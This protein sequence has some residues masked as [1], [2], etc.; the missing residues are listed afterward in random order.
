MKTDLSQM[1]R[2]VIVAGGLI[3]LMAGAHGAWA[4]GCVVGRSCQAGNIGSNFLMPGETEFTLSYRGF[5][6]NKHYNG[7]QRQH[8]RDIQKTFVINRQNIWNL[9]ATRG[10]TN[11]FSADIDIPYI[12]SGW[13]IPR[14]FP[15]PTTT[16]PTPLGPRYQQE[17]DG[18]GDIS[19]SGKYWLWDPE[20]HADSN[21]QLSLGIKAPTG[22][23][24]EQV[25]F[26][27]NSSA[28]KFAPTYID[29][30]IEPGDGGWG[31]PVGLEL[32][33]MLGKSSMTFFGEASYLINPRDTD[34]LV[35]RTK[36]A[37][38]T[39]FVAD[40]W[41]Q[42]S[43]PDQFLY[44]LGF[45][46]PLI[47]N[48]KR[49]ESLSGSLAWR[50]EGVPQHDLIGGSHGFRRAGYTM[51]VEPGLSWTKGS[52]TLDIDIP[53]TYARNRQPTEPNPGSVRP[54]DTTLA[55]SQLIIN[56]TRKFESIRL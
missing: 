33:K 9:I 35:H 51:S 34:G 8:Q 48:S 38:D 23:D 41:A 49:Q 31:F 54:G 12:K 40:K 37:S 16:P 18:L 21:V 55:D 42:N 43:V 25:L 2:P 24:H 13:S 5:K 10:L 56:Y 19:M 28:T 1:A 47:S 11:R 44:R 29:Q 15:D 27:S 26:P 4:Q 32:F 7:S 20:K 53:L 52:G 22:N 46:R 14:P 39:K 45:S 3:G 17:G 36:S 30:S 6:A 50:M